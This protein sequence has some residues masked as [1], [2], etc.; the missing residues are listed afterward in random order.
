MCINFDE[1]HSGG[2]SLLYV[3]DFFYTEI[4][5]IPIGTSTEIN[6]SWYIVSCPELGSDPP[7]GS[8][9]EL[10]RDIF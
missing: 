9:R 1:H 3:N 7:F 8:D 2:S 6:E 4:V 10:G 5:C